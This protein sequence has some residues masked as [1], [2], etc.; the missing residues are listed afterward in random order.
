MKLIKAFY[1]FA[2]I[3]KNLEKIYDHGTS[4]CT[5]F[6]FLVVDLKM[7]GTTFRAI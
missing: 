5:F 7:R 3:N 1:T 6:R 4:S 2:S